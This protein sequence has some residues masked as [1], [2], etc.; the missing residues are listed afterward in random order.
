MVSEPR[1]K[2]APDLAVCREARRIAL[3]GI[4]EIKATSIARTLQAVGI[5]AEPL[6]AV[7]LS[8]NNG[9]DGAIYDLEFSGSEGNKPDLETL[10]GKL[11]VPVLVI[12][13]GDDLLAGMD[14]VLR[15][16]DEFLTEPWCDSSLVLA[17]SRLLSRG[18]ISAKS[19]TLNPAAP[20]ILIADDDPSEVNLLR[21]LLG[22]RGMEPCVVSDG[23]AAISMIRQK[24]PDAVLL[25]VNMPLMSGLAV[26][27]KIRLDLGLVR[28]PVALLTSYSDSARV[29]E[30]LRLGANDY[31]VKPFQP[32][33]L[34]R[35]VARLL[36][37]GG[38]NPDAAEDPHETNSLQSWR[39]H[40]AAQ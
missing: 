19:A 23:L 22:H 7:D 27:A 28:L 32:A 20:L 33:E 29:S 6:S 12:G 3:V 31:I 37:L 16:A 24:L 14:E 30:A 9:L 35:R 18:G 1:E 25:D 39:V 13:H 26:L 34:T 38:K 2:Q 8:E 36:S 40:P 21:A 11:G 10:R 5:V 4:A 17:V 15:W